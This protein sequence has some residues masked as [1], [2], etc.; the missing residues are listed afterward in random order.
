MTAKFP[1]FRLGRRS[2]DALALPWARLKAVHQ[3]AA[4][5]STLLLACVVALL[6]ARSLL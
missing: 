6:L 1:K 4:P 2:V 3:T 5:A